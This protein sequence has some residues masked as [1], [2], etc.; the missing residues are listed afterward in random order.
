LSL[1]KFNYIIIITVPIMK[2]IKTKK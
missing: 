1:F 2:K